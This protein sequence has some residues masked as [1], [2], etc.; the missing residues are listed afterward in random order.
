MRLLPRSFLP[1]IA[2]SCGLLPAQAQIFTASN[3]GGNVGEFN[4]S[5]GAPINEYLITGLANPN[6]LVVSGNALYVTTET[7]QDAGT[8][9]RYNWNGTTASNPTT[10]ISGLNTPG[11]LVM[12]GSTLFVVDS[13]GGS[14]SAYNVSGATPTL[15]YSV[16]QLNPDSV[17]VSGSTLFVGSMYVSQLSETNTGFITAYNLSNGSQITTAVTGLD[18]I[19]ALAVSGGTLYA[20]TYF[21]NSIASFIVSGS[22]LYGENTA[23]ATGLNGPNALAID[24]GQLLVGN[25]NYNGYGYNSSIE[26][27]NAAT[28]AVIAPALVSNYTGIN[29]ITEISVSAVPEP[30][31]AIVVAAAA[32]L[33]GVAFW[34]SRG[35][36]GRASA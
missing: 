8:V 27:L 5:T 26:A 33:A 13:V 7:S 11:A 31:W 22:A 29:D 1:L 25:A 14:V 36:A 24:N 23:F 10:I 32:A 20:S 16:S 9:V 35:V 4:A 17:A 28:G 12:Y 2:L 19:S 18:G 21:N 15:L 30:S 6:G 3:G 34:R